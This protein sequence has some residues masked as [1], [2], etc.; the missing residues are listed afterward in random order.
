MHS[1]DWVSGT[2]TLAA[3]RPGLVYASISGFGNLVESPY[4]DWPAYAPIVEAMSGIYEYR[5]DP[6]TPPVLAPVG[7]L[8]DTAS[9]LFM[10]IGVLS[11]LRHRD[12]TG[13]GMRVDVAMFD[14]MIAMA[15]VVPNFWSLGQA[16]GRGQHR[17]GRVRRLPG[18]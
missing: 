11:A 15:D 17:R 7:A 16:P 14:V 18:A 2:T 5:R 8:G 6:D 4:A 13:E 10:M 3:L 1:R 9:G 12:R